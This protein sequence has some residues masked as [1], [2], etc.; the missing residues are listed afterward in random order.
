MCADRI[1]RNTFD[2]TYCRYDVYGQTNQGCIQ[3]TEVIVL[4][5]YDQNVWVRSVVE[6][7]HELD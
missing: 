4:V 7:S 1:G 6:R 3:E 2:S 5:S